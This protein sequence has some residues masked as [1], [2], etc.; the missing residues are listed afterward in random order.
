VE[1]V[2]F[3][4]VDTKPSSRPSVA[5]EVMS[6]TRHLQMMSR[7]WS[8]TAISAGN[9]NTTIT[10]QDT[11]THTDTDTQTHRHRHRHTHTAQ[12]SQPNAQTLDCLTD[13]NLL[14]SLPSTYD[15]PTIPPLIAPPRPSSSFSLPL[16]ASF[17]GAHIHRTSNGNRETHT[18]VHGQVEC[19]AKTPPESRPL[20]LWHCR[21]RT[22]C[23]RTAG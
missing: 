16:L 20:A 12:P 2:A 22:D 21:P 9:L 5:R 23:S 13:L 19:L 7:I 6:V 18:R 14:G 15:P 10:T 3:A 1:A 17:G 4:P 8:S 11:H